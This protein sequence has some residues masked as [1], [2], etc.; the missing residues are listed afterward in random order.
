MRE[1]ASEIVRQLQEKSITPACLQAFEQTFSV[2]LRATGIAPHLAAVR[3]D[4]QVEEIEPYL[5]GERVPQDEHE[6]QK[7]CS[8]FGISDPPS[9]TK[10]DRHRGSG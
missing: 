2:H 4:T 9:L 1:A 5:R 3:V 10:N 8:A 7:I 6:L